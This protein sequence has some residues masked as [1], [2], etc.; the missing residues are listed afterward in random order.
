MHGGEVVAPSG[1]IECVDSTG[2]GD[3]F[4]GGFISA[5]LEANGH[6][7]LED[8]LRYANAVAA[9][10]CRRPGARD[11]LPRRDEVAH[12]LRFLVLAA[13]VPESMR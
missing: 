12:A 13:A 3:A 4:R 10:A 5:L 7:A 8:V 1:R 6:A 11:A 9:L 2:A